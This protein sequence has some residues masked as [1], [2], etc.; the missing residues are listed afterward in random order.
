MA[1]GRRWLILFL[2]QG[3]RLL[4]YVILRRHG[5]HPCSDTTV[6]APRTF[7]RR[8]EG[9][10]LGAEP[11]LGTAALSGLCSLQLESASLLQ[12]WDVALLALEVALPAHRAKGL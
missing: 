11:G 5:L 8:G 9:S 12:S 4:V 3:A 6:Q 1:R 2:G 10:R 7:P